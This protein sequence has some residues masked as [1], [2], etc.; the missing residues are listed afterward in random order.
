MII[1]PKHKYIFFKSLKTA[2]SS[3][4]KALHD[5]LDES[6]FCSGGYDRMTESWEYEP[7]NQAM[8]YI[9][10]AG[11]QEVH[12]RFQQHTPPS[13]FFEKIKRP[14][15]YKP[16]R[17]ITIVRNPWDMIVS[18]YWY[19]ATANPKA[20][21]FHGVNLFINEKDSKKE[22]RRKINIW[23][24]MPFRFTSHTSKIDNP[25]GEEYII[26]DWLIDQQEK[27]GLSNH[28]TDFM[29]FEKLDSHF[30]ALCEYIGCEQR[31]LPRL[32][33]H[34]NKTKREHYSY[35]FNRKCEKLIE[36]RMSKFIDK[37]GYTFDRRVK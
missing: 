16:Y 8:V 24:H 25:D 22:A 18:Y 26:L 3:V 1:S 37:F 14:E 19:Q 11:E 23:L 13:Y 20:F 7:I 34:S 15:V 9:N 36:Q 17:T 10:E 5:T 28:I 12:D 2:G 6:S 31:E 29:R 21:N 4:E 33:S 32:K 30:K 27:F 35:Y